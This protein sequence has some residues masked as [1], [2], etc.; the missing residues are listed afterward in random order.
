MKID[1]LPILSLILGFCR[2]IY[3]NNFSS[4]KY[5]VLRTETKNYFNSKELF[6]NSKFES[7][8]I[9]PNLIEKYFY[10]ETGIRANEKSIYKL[11]SFKDKLDGN[12]TW[13]EIKLVQ[14]YLNFEKSDI[15]IKITR[16]GKLQS[17]IGVIL[18]LILVLTSIFGASYFSQ[19][20]IL[21]LRDI[22]IYG[23]IISV[24]FGVGYFIISHIN[25]IIVS[26]QMENKLKTKIQS[27]N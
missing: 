10:L 26:R 9:R 19:F 3:N 15:E 18:S 13:R 12:Y 6:S 5:S 14:N 16:L 7:D 24:P 1:V 11:I 27:K 25:P 17:I 22:L 20:E 2:K 21:E 8:F 4:H 23:M